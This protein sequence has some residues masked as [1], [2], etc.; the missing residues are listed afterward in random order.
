M[1]GTSRESMRAA[2][3][4]SEERAGDAGGAGARSA[5]ACTPSPACSTGSRRC[6]GHSPTRRRARTAGAAWSTRCSAAACRPVPCRCWP[7]WSPRSWRSP[8]DLREAVETLAAQ[9][10]LVAAEGDGVLDDVEDELF[11]FA[12][13]LE[14]E[15]ELRAAL[16]DPG[17]PEERKSGL[18]RQAARRP[19]PP[20]RPCGWSRWR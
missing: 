20:G 16:T 17:L 7:T 11:R 13:L 4:R 19:G 1:E 18:L 14:R 8:A 15:P 10:A 9:A 2:L 12:R 6:A 3:A 5:R